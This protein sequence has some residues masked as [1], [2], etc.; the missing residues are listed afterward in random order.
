M[1]IE[2]DSTRNN[3]SHWIYTILAKS[4]VSLPC[5]FYEP[6]AEMFNLPSSTDFSVDPRT[7]LLHGILSGL[8][9]VR[10]PN[11]LDIQTALQVVRNAT[12]V[13]PAMREASPAV[14]LTDVGR[15]AVREDFVE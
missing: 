7:A 8:I 10:D 2:I 14:G 12:L 4:D 6:V 11:L 15:N 13:P 3:L 9:E 1:S 5:F